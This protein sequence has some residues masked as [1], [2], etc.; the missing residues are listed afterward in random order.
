MDDLLL[1]K[2]LRNE[3]SEEGTRRGTRL[4]G[5]VNGKPAV[6]RSARLYFQSQY[7]GRRGAAPC[8]QTHCFALEEGGSMECRGRGRAARMRRGE[9]L[10]GRQDSRTPYPGHDGHYRAQRAEHVRHLERRDD[11]MAQFGRQIGIPLDLFQKDTPGQDFG[12]GHVRGETRRQPS[13]HR[14]NIRL[15]C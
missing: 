4:V 1:Q 2:Y 11:R 12:R 5:R 8:Q 6:S 15:R 10:Y 14:G 7:S 3:T 9:P 13:V